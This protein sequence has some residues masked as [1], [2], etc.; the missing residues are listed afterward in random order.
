MST[1][2]AVMDDVNVNGHEDIGS[3]YLT[4]QVLVLD[5]IVRPEQPTCLGL[6]V[7]LIITREHELFEL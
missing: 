4:V 5:G 6:I 7:S 1:L 3:L 2:A